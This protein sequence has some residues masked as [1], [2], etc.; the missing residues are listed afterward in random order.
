MQL[1][2]RLYKLLHILNH[3]LHHLHSAERFAQRFLGRRAFE[4]IQKDRKAWLW[5]FF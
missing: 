2:C 5:R 1:K 4:E 3:R